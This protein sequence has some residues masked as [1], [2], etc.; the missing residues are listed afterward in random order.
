MK[1]VESGTVLIINQDSGKVPAKMAELRRL[2]REHGLKLR[3]CEGSELDHEIREMLKQK[4]LK[5]IIVGGG[6]GSVNTAASL[7]LKAKQSIELAVLPLGTANYYAKSL[8]LNRNL[9]K[10]FRVA[11]G[12]KV[13]SRHV[14]RANKRTFLIGV[15]IGTTSRMFMEVTDDEK[16]RFGRL[17]YFRGVFR[18][19][20]KTTSPDLEVTANGQ[21]KSYVS[22][23]MVI[24]NQYIQEPVKLTPQVQGGDPYFEI[25][26]YGLG[27]SKL[28]PLFAVFMFAL[29][30]G[31]NQKYLKRIQATKAIIRSSKQQ[32]VAIDGDSLEELPLKVEL[33]EKP[34]LFM[35]A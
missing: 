5:R 30:L 11:V 13:E 25:I 8:G 34:I 31:R 24:L 3:M 12:D 7:I 29:T 15:N 1:K 4:N 22:T 14:C 17:A 2:A 20:L 32:S 18:V 9:A 26:T 33:V 27:R 21:T 28:S 10:A 23:E 16:Q 6:D 35:R 19:L